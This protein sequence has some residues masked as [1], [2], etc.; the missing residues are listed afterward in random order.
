MRA[1]ASEG[2][3]HLGMTAH[4]ASRKALSVAHFNPNQ[5][6][7]RSA[8]SASLSVGDT[9]S[10]TEQGCAAQ[11]RDQRDEL[12]ASTSVDEM[13][14]SFQRAASEAAHDAHDKLANSQLQ[15]FT[16]Y[17]DSYLG[18]RGMQVHDLCSQIQ[19][20]VLGF[21]LLEALEG[22]VAV[23][24]VRGRIK[25]FGASIVAKPKIRIERIENLNAF[26]KVLTAQKGIHLVNIGGEDLEE[27]K[28]DLVLGLTFEIV[29]HYE[30][31][32]GSS[33]GGGGGG[34]SASGGGAAGSCSKTQDLLDWMLTQ[35]SAFGHGHG[36]AGEQGASGGASS[37]GGGSRWTKLLQDGRLLCALFAMMLPGEIDYAASESWSSEERLRRCFA[38]G[39]S[40][41]APMLLDASDVAHGATDQISLVTYIGA[42]RKALGEVAS[43]EA[44]KEARK[45]ASKKAS[46]AEGKETS[47]AAGKAAG[48][49][50][51]KVASEEA[52]ASKAASAGGPNRAHDV[53]AVEAAVRADEMLAAAEMTAAEAAAMEMAAAQKADATAKAEQAAK[54]QA[55]A[56]RAAA[57]KAAEEEEAAASAAARA[58]AEAAEAEKAKAKAAAEQTGAATRAVEPNS[59]AQRAVERGADAARIDAERAAAEAERRRR[60]KEEMAERA[61]A[62]QAAA[63]LAAM[64]KEAAEKAAAAAAKASAAAEEEVGAAKEMAAAALAEAAAAAKVRAA[65]AASGAA[66]VRTAEE[67]NARKGLHLARQRSIKAQAALGLRRQNTATAMEM[68]GFAAPD[69]VGGPL[70]GEVGVA[71]RAGGG[72]LARGDSGVDARRTDARC[73][74]VS[75]RNVGLGLAA[76][77]VIWW[78]VELSVKAVRKARDA[79]S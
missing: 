52:G 60:Q 32:G 5:F 36:D 50:A 53:A 33:V 44:S 1:R 41:G 22:I 62:N 73:F 24:V 28:L 12:V 75:S 37:R 34:D 40:V 69:Q 17:W 42:L 4:E 29:K 65:E 77:I 19:D 64:E 15:T 47:K 51:G 13:P 39:A 72:D 66:G 11:R 27:G 25:A 6:I 70:H 49:E 20:G 63:T 68:A 16:R 8:R 10:I 61:T 7:S 59:S 31:G 79:R 67:A 3:R 78:G 9:P 35:A 2:R 46:K 74:A 30:L 58:L 26:L 38:A 57:K 23:P 56:E 21:R 18:P 76:M 54:A 48:K 71:G 14:P 55:A 45:E 43:K